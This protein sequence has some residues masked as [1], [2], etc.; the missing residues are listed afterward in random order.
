M[1]ALTENGGIT[2]SEIKKQNTSERGLLRKLKHFSFVWEDFPSKFIV[3]IYTQFGHFRSPL[4]NI[5][6]DQEFEDSFEI[7]QRREII[8]SQEGQGFLHL[9]A[10]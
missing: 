8:W 10:M 2:W 6:L 1:T 7:L 5:S 9:L 4:K 3:C